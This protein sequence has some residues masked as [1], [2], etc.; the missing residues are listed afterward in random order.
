METNNIILAG[1]MGLSL[2]NINTA[3]FVAECT[4]DIEDIKLFIEFCRKHKD[5]IEYSTKTEKLD[6]LSIRYKKQQDEAKIPLE[7]L[8][9]FIATLDGKVKESRNFV[10]DKNI[11]FSELVVKGVKYFSKKELEALKSCGS[12]LGIIEASRVG[13]LKD[14]LRVILSNKFLATVNNSNKINNRVIKMI[15]ARV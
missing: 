2:E 9:G 13:I 15:G 6:T 8:N 10:E 1:V 7:R 12:N 14:N 4:K 5:G 11:E 3:I